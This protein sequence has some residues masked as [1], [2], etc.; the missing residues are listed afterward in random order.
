MGRVLDRRKL[1]YFA[2]ILRAFF[3]IPMHFV[4][5]L[6]YLFPRDP[7]VWLFGCWEGKQI[8][9]N[10]KYFYLYS[11]G[12][13]SDIE[14]VWMT[15]SN[16]VYERLRKEGLPVQKYWSLQ[17]IWLT[18]RAKYLFCSH[19]VVDHNVY[20]TG[21]ARYINMSHTTF[22][23]KDMRLYPSPKYFKRALQYFIDPYSW[24]LKMDRAAVVSSAVIDNVSHQFGISLTR[25]LPFG[26]AK[27]DFLLAEDKRNYMLSDEKSTAGMLKKDGSKCVLYLPTWR[28]DPCFSVF[29]YGFDKGLLNQK[30]MELNVKLFINFHPFMID[31]SVPDFSDCRQI[32]PC[33]SSGDEMN[34]MLEGADILITDYSA[35]FADFLLFDRPLIFA[36]FDYE[37]YKKR[38][39]MVLNYDDLP[40]PKVRSW[41]GGGE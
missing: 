18:L 41:G 24:F 38:R 14:S 2:R 26:V 22:A 10:V 17:G 33:V 6:S 36:P 11:L 4:F 3:L 20:F 27:S 21:R 37:D 12:R 30:L 7:K 31:R 39:K 29:N 35:L 1:E 34:L 5:L 28:E 8:R 19:G 25:L 13:E 23:I 15:K 9:G 16:D 40:G 32:V